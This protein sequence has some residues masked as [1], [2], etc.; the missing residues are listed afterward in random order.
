M[1]EKT[2]STMDLSVYGE[3]DDANSISIED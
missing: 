2:Y 3:N 1:K